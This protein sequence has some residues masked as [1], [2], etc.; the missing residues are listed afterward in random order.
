MRAV[1]ASS[2]RP[3]KRRESLMAWFMYASTSS[4]TEAAFRSVSSVMYVDLIHS[5][6][7]C[8]TQSRFRSVLTRSANCLASAAVGLP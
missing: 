2:F 1:S 3:S 7:D 6:V 5:A 4:L 8:L